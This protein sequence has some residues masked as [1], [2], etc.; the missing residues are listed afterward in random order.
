MMIVGTYREMPGLRLTLA[1][2][3]RLFGGDS[4]ICRSTLDDLVRRGALSQDQRGSY[5]LP[6][7]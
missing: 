7:R 3:E 1:Q 6:R 5:I 2:A 4:T